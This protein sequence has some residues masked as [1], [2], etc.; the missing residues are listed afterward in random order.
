MRDLDQ[1]SLGSTLDA[2]AE[3]IFFGRRLT[4]GPRNTAAGGI[5][6][7]QGLPGAY[8]EMFAPTQK[9]YRG[10]RLFTGERVRSRVGITHLLGEE[11]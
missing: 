7:R 11:S 10:L 9:D 2:I 4:V 6:R 5:A 8:A 1:T 3:T